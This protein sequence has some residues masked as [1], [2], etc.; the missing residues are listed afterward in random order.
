MDPSEAAEPGSTEMY[1][2]SRRTKVI[3][4]TLLALTLLVSWPVAAHYRARGKVQD[5]KRQLQARGEK[6]MIDELVPPP[7]AYDSNGAAALMAAASQLQWSSLDSNSPPSM[8]YIGPGRAMVAWQQEIL[9]TADSTDIWPGLRKTLAEEEQELAA[10]R[11]ALERPVVA[12][13]LNYAHG[14]SLLLPHL[15]Q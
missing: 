1:A 10:I 5:Y 15:A 6:L 13:D 12:F 11:A 8:K 7:P 4:V 3:A 9:P 2:M 14:F